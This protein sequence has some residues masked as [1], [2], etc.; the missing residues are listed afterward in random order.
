M[1]LEIR[2][3]YKLLFRLL[4]MF[5]PTPILVDQFIEV[6]QDIAA[7]DDSFERQLHCLYRSMLS[8]ELHRRAVRQKDCQ[9]EING[10]Y[11][12]IEPAHTGSVWLRPLES[13]G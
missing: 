10:E 5:A 2:F 6:Q 1:M 7:E 9:V 4:L 11:Y 3:H 8:A 12:R 13:S